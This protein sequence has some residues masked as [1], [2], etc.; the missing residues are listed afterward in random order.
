MAARRASSTLREQR[1]RR[2]ADY[3]ARLQQLLQQPPEPMTT[4]DALA[5]REQI[6]RS[7]DSTQ[8]SLPL[9]PIL[10]KGSPS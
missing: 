9:F 10:P 7:M 4:N 8:P 2:S 5:L 1:L 3:A 6:S